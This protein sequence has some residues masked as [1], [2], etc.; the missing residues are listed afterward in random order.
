MLLRRIPHCKITTIFAGD[1]PL[2]ARFSVLRHF[3]SSLTEC[4][5]LVCTFHK[6]LGAMFLLSSC[7]CIFPLPVTSLT[8][9][10]H[11]KFGC[12]VLEGDID[13]NSW[14]LKFRPT[15]RAFR[16]CCGFVELFKANQT[17]RMVT[18]QADGLYHGVE[19]VSD[20]KEIDHYSVCLEYTTHFHATCNLP[21]SAL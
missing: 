7:P 12:N 17:S 20:R 16:I 11:S 18:A 13:R 1:L 4:A 9:A 6:Q 19:T 5:S 14:C 3:F 21:N 2:A 15:H 8:L 10:L